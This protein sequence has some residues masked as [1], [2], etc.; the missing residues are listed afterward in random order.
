MWTVPCGLLAEPKPL[1]LSCALPVTPGGRG[2]GR[3]VVFKGRFGNN[4]LNLT[5]CFSGILN[6][7]ALSNTHCSV[8]LNLVL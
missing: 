4:F 8:Q 2:W 6:V 3:E 5:S 1:S 7:C